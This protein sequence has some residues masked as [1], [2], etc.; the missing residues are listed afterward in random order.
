MFSP[1][2]RRSRCRTSFS[3]RPQPRDAIRHRASGGRRRR[4]GRQSLKR[5]AGTMKHPPIH[6]TTAKWPAAH[7]ARRRVLQ[8]Q[9]SPLSISSS[10]RYDCAV[11]SCRRTAQCLRPHRQTRFFH[12]RV[13][14]CGRGL[15]PI[16]LSDRGRVI[17]HRRGA[18]PPAHRRH[19]SAGG[20]TRKLDEGECSATAA[21]WPIPPRY[22]ECRVAGY[23]TPR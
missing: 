12:C 17:W 18:A 7:Q 15:R 13:D 20:P 19:R 9:I 23:E 6:R 11:P 21:S 16:W 2:M 3:S 1:P 10:G 8:T 14:E 4:R 5:T 22:E